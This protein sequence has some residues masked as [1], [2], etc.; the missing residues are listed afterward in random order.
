MKAL[1]D[2]AVP[3]EGEPG[4]LGWKQVTLPGPDQWRP[5]GVSAR[6][7]P[8]WAC[9]IPNFAR[10]HVY[11][12]A[13]T[14]FVNFDFKSC[15]F[16]IAERLL[17]TTMP[18]STFF[19]NLFAGGDVYTSIAGDLGLTRDEAKL[20]ALQL[21]NGAEKSTLEPT[22]GARAAEVLAAWKKNNP[23]VRYCSDATTKISNAHNKRS[24]IACRMQKMEAQLLEATLVELNA[25]PVQFDVVLPLFDGGLLLC[26]E[27]DAPALK[28]AAGRAGKTAAAA[29]GMPEMGME[30]GTG[31]T[32]WAAQEN[33]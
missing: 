19:T 27:E 30:V 12:P 14:L 2:H 6:L 21:L 13:G 11:A 23:W 7:L 33:G 3:V 15:H 22:L 32:W 8:D 20:I 31:P 10:G 29:L 24:V 9:N 1:L 17:T 26:R 18:K 16:R 4:S 25:Q 5:R 28:A